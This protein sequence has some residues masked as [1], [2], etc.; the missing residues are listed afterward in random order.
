VANRFDTRVAIVHRK[1]RSL[2]HGLWVFSLSI[3][4]ENREMTNLFLW[5]FSFFF[6]SFSLFIYDIIFG[7]W[8]FLIVGVGRFSPDAVS[9]F[10]SFRFGQFRLLSRR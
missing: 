3:E 1:I 5:D 4:Y 7:R 2:G 9:V 10:C 6:I 8:R